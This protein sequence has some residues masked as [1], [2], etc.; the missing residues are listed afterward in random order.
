MRLALSLEQSGH[1]GQLLCCQQRPAASG[2]PL[3]PGWGSAILRGG[4]GPR[5]YSG[6]AEPT[7][8]K[9]KSTPVRA[10]P[11]GAEGTTRGPSL[12][13]AGTAGCDER[14]FLA[15]S[16]CDGRHWSLI[17]WSA[18]LLLPSSR[19]YHI[20]TPLNG[21]TVLRWLPLLCGAGAYSH[22]QPG[23]KPAIVKKATAQPKNSAPRSS[24][25]LHWAYSRRTD[26]CDPQRHPNPAV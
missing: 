17:S 18:C 11:A 13:R 4:E 25:L 23:Q 9:K 3:S 1:G 22:R 6:S 12:Q 5:C 2:H 14:V 15:T 24:S 7:P 19:H 21:L 26:G 16:K 8:Q 20:R 10:Y